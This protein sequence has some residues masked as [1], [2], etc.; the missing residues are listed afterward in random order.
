[1][2]T[3]YSRN[4]RRDVTDAFCA[5]SQ[6]IKRTHEITKDRSQ[7]QKRRQKFFQAVANSHQKFQKLFIT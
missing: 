4:L 5:V 3:A 7:H 1:M 6:N 2:T